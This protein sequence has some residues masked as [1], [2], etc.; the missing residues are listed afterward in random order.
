MTKKDFIEK[1][2]ISMLGNPSLTSVLNG[3]HEDVW[4]FAEEVWA[5]NPNKGSDPD[6]K[7]GSNF[8]PPTP[9]QVEDYLLEKGKK[10]SFT[11]NQF[12][13]H[14][15]SK[16]WF[17]GKNKMKDWKAAVRT[18]LAKKEQSESTN[19]KKVGFIK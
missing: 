11:G 2:V 9:Q 4:T 14:Y 18:W 3:N 10:G 5:A 17:I 13:N 7:R 16:G 19:N 8:T 6:K 12:C 1:A 15:D